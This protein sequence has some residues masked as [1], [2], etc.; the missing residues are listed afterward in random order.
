MTLSPHIIVD[1]IDPAMLQRCLEYI[2]RVKQL[3]FV[4][5]GA[6]SQID[7]G[8]AFVEQVHQARP[9]IRIVWRNLDPEDTGILARPDYTPEKLYAEKVTKHLKWFQ[10]NKVIFMPDNETSGD[11]DRIKLY[12]RDEAKIAQMLHA[13][14]LNGAFCRFA[15]G[16]IG[17]GSQ[18]GQSNQYPLLKPIFDAMNAGDII[19]PNEYRNKPNASSGGHLFRYDLMR[20]AAG[21]KL[22]VFIGEAGVSVD[23]NPGIGYQAIGLGDAEVCQLM[24]GD[25]IWYE[26][27]AIDRS[28][29]LI[30]G[31]THETFRWRPGIFDYLEKHYEKLPP[32]IQP[33]IPPT[34]SLPAFPSDFDARAVRAMAVAGSPINVRKQPSLTAPILDTLRQNTIAHYIPGDKLR[35]DEKVYSTVGSINALWIPIAL[36]QADNGRGWVWAGAVSWKAIPPFETTALILLY[37]NVLKASTRTRQMSLELATISDDLLKDADL[38]DAL[39]KSSESTVK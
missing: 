36:N 7:R 15:T 4:N 20:K 13:D 33:P 10:D 25:E 23:Y 16:N 31:Y 26:N 39:I 12:A 5:I 21:R 19:S 37:N 28:W 9:D 35:P 22:T 30:G 17:D 34:P 32:I 11:D 24:L 6:G 29:Y 3:R 27:G 18:P 1:N 8:M 2:Q 14:G 38:L